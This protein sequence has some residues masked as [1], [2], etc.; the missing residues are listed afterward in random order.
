[1]DFAS[2]FVLL[3]IGVVVSG[4]LHYGLKF[5]IRAGTSSF[6]SKVVIGYVGAWQGG[7]VLGSWGPSSERVYYVPAILGSA[8][9][10]LLVVDVVKTVC[11]AATEEDTPPARPATQF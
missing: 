2:F 8:A 10:L 5:Y 4:I 7:S 3:I 9:L 1:M 6:L 11:P